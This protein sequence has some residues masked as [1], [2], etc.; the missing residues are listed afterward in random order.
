M[1][2]DVISPARLQWLQKNSEN[3]Y[4]RKSGD[5]AKLRIYRPLHDQSESDSVVEATASDTS[6]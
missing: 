2:G 1:G 3:A 5:W 6:I 4:V